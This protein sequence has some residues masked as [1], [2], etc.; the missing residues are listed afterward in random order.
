MDNGVARVLQ[1]CDV[2]AQRA[3]PVELGE[4]VDGALDLLFQGGPLFFDDVRLVHSQ[5]D[6]WDPGPPVHA[7]RRG[8]RVH[9]YRISKTEFL[10]I[11]TA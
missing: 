10:S 8:R 3:F 11:V 4:S 2:D 5:D 9:L 6:E 1:A 7:A